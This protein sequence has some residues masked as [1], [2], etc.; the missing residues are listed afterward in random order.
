MMSA[1]RFATRNTGSEDLYIFKIVSLSHKVLATHILTMTMYELVYKYD[2]F[3][4][5]VVLFL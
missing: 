2:L 3:V 1:G 5:S 4:D